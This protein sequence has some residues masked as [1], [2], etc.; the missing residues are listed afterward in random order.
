MCCRE[1]IGIGVEIGIGIRNWNWKCI[2]QRT[3]DTRVQGVVKVYG[4]REKGKGAW[5]VAVATSKPCDWPPFHRYS[6]QFAG[7]CSCISASVSQFAFLDAVRIL[8]FEVAINCG[9]PM[10]RNSL[11]ITT[12]ITAVSPVYSRPPFETPFAFAA[13]WFMANCSECVNVRLLWLLC[14]LLRSVF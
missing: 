4:W 10:R 9:Q 8:M 6:I 13:C 5:H 2:V 11:I 14:L 12:T 7:C 3:S 1:R